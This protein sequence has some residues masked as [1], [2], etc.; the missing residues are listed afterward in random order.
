MASTAQD[1]SAPLRGPE[2]K[3]E[4]REEDSTLTH[5]WTLIQLW[6]AYRSRRPLKLLVLVQLSILPSMASK[7]V[8]SCKKHAAS[9]IPT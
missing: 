5:S 2:K 1:A 3:D 7:R 8:L 4:D 6:Q 9:T